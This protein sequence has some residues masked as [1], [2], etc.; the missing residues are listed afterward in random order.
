[1]V[2]KLIGKARSGRRGR[3][4]ATLI[5]VASHG[6]HASEVA[7]LEWSQI[8]ADATTLHV[9]HAKNGEPSAHPLRGGGCTP[10]PRTYRAG[11]YE[12]G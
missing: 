12:L 11:D 8:E 9:R 5:L 1:M 3:G 7:D 4:D 2:E 10:G 6:L